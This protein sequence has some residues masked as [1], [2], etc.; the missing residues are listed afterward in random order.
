MTSIG[1]YDLV[2]FYPNGRGLAKMLENIMAKYELTEERARTFI[3]KRLNAEGGYQDFLYKII[4]DY[5]S[6]LFRGS[7]YLDKIIFEIK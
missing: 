7:P 2:V 6:I 1:L 3:E 4:E 5:S